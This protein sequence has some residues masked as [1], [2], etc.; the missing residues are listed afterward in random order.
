MTEVAAAVGDFFYI[1]GQARFAHIVIEAIKALIAR[2]LTGEHRERD[3]TEFFRKMMAQGRFMLDAFTTFAPSAAASVH[4]FAPYDASEVILHNNDERGHWMV[5]RG[6]VY[7][8]SE[9]MYI[10]PGGERLIVTSAGM[11][12]TRSY[13]KAE[14]HLNPE[15]H[16][17]PGVTAGGVSSGRS[18]LAAAACSS[19]PAID[20]GLGGSM[21]DLDRSAGTLRAGLHAPPSNVRGAPLDMRTGHRSYSVRR[22][23]TLPRRDPVR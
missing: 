6:L 21:L 17:S 5:I 7:D 23:S 14:H 4:G 11:D 8:M 20:T 22:N 3:A 18:R 13:E 16:A 15:V 12:G 10:H 9:F 2:R 1:C 19:R